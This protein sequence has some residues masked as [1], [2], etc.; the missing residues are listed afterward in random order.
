MEYLLFH[1]EIIL[2]D[3]A[4]VKI[5]SRLFDPDQMMEQNV[6]AELTRLNNPSQYIPVRL[7]GLITLCRKWSRIYERRRVGEIKNLE[8]KRSK[9]PLT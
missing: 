9:P 3:V 7:L 8:R 1:G 6:Y 2:R 4:V 5:A